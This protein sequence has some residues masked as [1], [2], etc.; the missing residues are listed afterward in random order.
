M[1]KLQKPEEVI[2]HLSESEREETEL[3][4]IL[5]TLG[6]PEDVHQEILEEQ[7][8][9]STPAPPATPFS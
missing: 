3:T 5:A 1:Y 7:G 2:L 4:A 6:L 9:P 8:R